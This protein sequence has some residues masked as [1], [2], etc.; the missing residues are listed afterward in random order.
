MLY[1]DPRVHLDEVV[2]FILIHEELQCSGVGIAHVLS[3]LDS[4]LIELLLGLLGY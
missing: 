1:L 4:V 2:I 3:D